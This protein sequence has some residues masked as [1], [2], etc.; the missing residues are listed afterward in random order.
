MVK[1]KSR[2]AKPKPQNYV[3]EKFRL[4]HMRVGRL[5]FVGQRISWVSENSQKAFHSLSNLH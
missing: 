5:L 3:A 1:E 4:K 2:F